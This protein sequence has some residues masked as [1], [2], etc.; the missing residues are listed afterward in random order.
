[1]TKN[2]NLIHK[3]EA[4]PTLINALKKDSFR[5]KKT[6]ANFTD[7]LTMAKEVIQSMNLLVVL[8]LF[9]IKKF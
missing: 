1:V 3:Q 6:V 9:G 4:A 7:A 8:A 2:Q 5:T